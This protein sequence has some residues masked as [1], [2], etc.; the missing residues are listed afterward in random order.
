V[1]DLTENNK[2]DLSRWAA[3]ALGGVLLFLG[4]V[5]FDQFYLAWVFLVPVLWAIRD[6][7]PGRA[8]LIGWLAGLVG[9]AGGFYW[10]IGM[11][12]VFAG[13]PWPLAALGLLGLAAANGVLI[14]AWAWICRITTRHTRLSLVV[15]APVAW[16]A[17]EKCWPEIFP[18]YLGASQYR[19]SY[20]T[21]VA[22]IFGILGVSFLVVLINATVYAA[23][24]GWSTARRVAWRPL[25][26]LVVVLMLVIAYGG[27]RIKEVDRQAAAA[28]QLRVGLV[29]TNQG[30]TA[31]YFDPEAIFREHQQMSLALVQ[32]QPLDLIVWPEGIC[33]IA[34]SPSRT[35]Q[36]PAFDAFKTP[37]L[38]GS[39]LKEQGPQGRVSNTALLTDA[40][41]RILGTYDKSILV[42]FGEYIPLGDRFPILYAWSPYTSRFWPGQTEEPLA[43]GK[44]L[45]SVSIC[46]EDIFPE[47]IRSL[48]RGGSAGRR[49]D[50]LFNLTN[51]SWYGKSTEP[52]EHLVLA[53]FRSIENRRALVRVTNTGISALVDP[54]GRIVS[55]TG[56]WT[57]ETLAGKIPLLQGDTFY[58]RFGDLLGW[59]SV[60]VTAFCIGYALKTSKGRGG[61]ESRPGTP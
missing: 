21:Q 26:S 17:L 47:K 29:Q 43:L 57:K 55:R 61:G 39:V 15:V 41:G 23:A 7:R 33:D 27:Y 34:L 24:A 18:N 59:L 32:A 13:L 35:G 4:Y 12:Q 6:Q 56:V 10:V 14:G 2:T 1:P 58:A 49:P 36:V 3:A 45:L 5:G 37:V 60:L 31:K 28:E 9:H 30:G 44:H 8:F 42:P 25:A 11:F 38:W 51:D 46:Y 53:S 48:M 40:A 20:L 52:L 19:L 50:A 22:D 54:V 16:T